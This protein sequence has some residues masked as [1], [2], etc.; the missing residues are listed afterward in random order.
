VLTRIVEWSLRFRG[1]AIALACASVVWGVHAALRAKL[2]V[3]PDFAPPQAVIQTEAP[4]F[5]A[6]Q[7]ESLVTT[8]IE[9]ELS[10]VEGLESLRSE[11]IQGLSV[12]TATFG[13]DRDV[14]AVRQWLAERLSTL[15]GQLPLAA[16][17]PK[18]EPLTSA[19]MD[20]LKIGLVS[21]RLDARDLR[22]LASWTVAP[23]LRAV[24]G[25]ARVN[26]FGGEVRQLQVQLRPDDLLAHR[27]AAADVIA[28]ARRATGVFGAGFVD[29]PNQRIVL[30]T[31]GQA[32]DPAALGAVVVAAGSVAPVRLRDVARVAEGA[33]P[34]FGD[35]LIQGR[36][37]V[38]LSLSSQYGSNTL[39]VTRDLERALAEL[40]P[41]L[42]QKGVQL[43]PR[44]HRPAS[45]I[46]HAL[47][48]LRTS[49]LFGGV[50][51][52]AVLFAFLGDLRTTLISLAA[53][54]LSLLGAVI[55]LER[56]SIALDTMTLGGIAIAIGE[57]VDDAI[58][59]IE[60]ITRR[61]RENQQRADPLSAYRVVH[62]AAVEVR[63]PV[64]YATFV[65]A[66]VFVP[67][68]TLSGLAGKFFAPLGLAYLLAVMASLIVAVTVTP[69]LALT[70]YGRD[71]VHPEEPRLQRR[72]KARYRAGLARRIERPRTLFAAA[73]VAAVVA[74]AVLPFLRGGFL[75]PFRE[76]HLVL[77][78]SEAPGA[79][80]DEMLRVGRSLSA[81]L[82]AVPGIATVEQQVGRAEQGEDT[83]GPHRSEFHV[84]LDSDGNGQ[85]TEI[86]DRVR[87][88]L[89]ETPGLQFE[90][91]TFLGDRISETL[92]GETAPVVVSLF[93]PELEIL[94]AKAAEIARVLASVDGASEVQMKARP[95][96][97]MLAVRLRG[98]ALA[99]FGFL[100]VDVLEAVQ[101]AYQGDVVAQVH[102]AD[103]AVDVVVILADDRRRDPSAVG[104]LLVRGSTGAV[105]HLRELADV[106]PG[107]GR[108]SILHEGSR[109]R[110]TVTC[111]PRGR[112]LASFVAEARS[113]VDQRIALPAGYYVE[114]GGTAQTQAAARRELLMKCGMAGVGILILLWL[115]FRTT[116][117][118]ALVLANVPFGLPGAV[119]ALLLARP[120]APDAG[121]LSMGALVGFVTLFG[122]SMR[123]SLLL[124]AH[125][126]FLV[127]EEGAPWN[128]ETAIRGATDRV[129]PIL[130][131]ALVTGLGL[132]PLALGAGTAG[133]EIE[134]PMAT[135]IVGGLVSSTALTL[136]VLPAL[137]HRFGRFAERA[138]APRAD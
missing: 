77:Q 127:F 1:I 90:V 70:F 58:I 105:R 68:L 11:S 97:P 36:A 60:N 71:P 129:V 73:L 61:L 86:I 34:R 32:L 134:G 57:V 135:V 22:D 38:L 44:L 93:G 25:V 96:A 9:A 103:H 112:D 94:D 114:F 66:L 104:S 126:R 6:E 107:D 120:F 54:P 76:G 51:I 62:A 85:E 122:I 46:E 50:L 33:A 101:L 137:A 3:F 56:F 37:G 26:V 131:T 88:L 78:V 12:I 35:S 100:P 108:L 49:V 48:N 31:E 14:Y 111:V 132:L 16:A 27:L 82:L 43:Y 39:D 7:V 69:A 2:D 65:V 63:G 47:R 83:W 84:E 91:L 99:A 72:I 79:S 21:D 116:R 133:R 113:A 130:M 19:T 117:S 81:A 17:P 102:H 23:K 74:G 52:V 123:N 110:Q 4:G 15:A 8:P 55:V 128:V 42:D 53:I 10:G 119:V 118:V 28:A 121:G 92:T 40:G 115:A 20:V 109:R 64:V 89:A 67:L 5:A 138:G 45:F 41:V 75:P 59:G 95:G 29:T 124:I 80:I 98:D 18:I 13:E 106:V 24:P 87:A 30:R 136:L 125:Y